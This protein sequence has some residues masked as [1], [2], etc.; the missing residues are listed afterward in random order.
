[1]L[2]FSQQPVALGLLG[3][4]DLFRICSRPSWDVKGSMCA[5]A[6]ARA[7]LLL[8]EQGMLSCVKWPSTR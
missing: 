2:G 1:M 5:D 7:V 6:S 8:S 3:G 4:R